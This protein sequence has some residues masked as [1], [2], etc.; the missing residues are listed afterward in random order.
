MRPSHLYKLVAVLVCKQ[1]G[2]VAQHMVRILLLLVLRGAVGGARERLAH[3]CAAGAEAEAAGAPA[4]RVPPPLLVRAHL[5]NVPHDFAAPESGT[6]NA[7]HCSTGQPRA[8]LSA[9]CL[10]QCYMYM[11]NIKGQPAGKVTVPESTI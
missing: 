11:Q 3:A 6:M 4:L 1:R 9:L 7:N 5:R 10:S 2:N 8:W